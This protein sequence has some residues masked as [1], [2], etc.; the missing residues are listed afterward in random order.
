MSGKTVDDRVVQ[1]RFDNSQFE[2]NV[3]TSMSTLERLKNALKFKNASKGLD[4][5]KNAAKGVNMDA[6]GNSV[7]KVKH[8]FSALE[9]VGVTALANITNSAVNAGKNMIK[10]LTLDPIITGFQEYET[11]IN[12]VQTIMSNTA[13]KGTTMADVTR[14]LD[15]LN[16]YADLTIYNFAEMTRNIGTFTAAG[17]G[18]EDSASAIKGIANLAA[19]SGSNSYQASTAMYQ[20]SQ[21]LAAGTVK[22]MDWNSVVNAGM[23]GEKFQNALKAT[24]REMGIAVDSIIEKNGSFRD[25][26][27]AGWLTADVLNTT[28]KKFTREGAAEYAQAMMDAGKWT[29][30]QADALMKEAIMMEDAATK[31]KTFTQLWDTMKESVQSGWAQSWELIVGDFEEA[32]ASLTELSDVFGTFIQSGADARNAMLETAMSSNWKKLSKEITSLG[33]DLEEFKG[34]LIDVGVQHGV[35]T[36]E[37]IDEAGSFEQSLKSGW[38]TTDIFAEA[39]QG[40]KDTAIEFGA[41]TDS[42]QAKLDEFQGKVAA[43]WGDQTLGTVEDRIMALEAAGYDFAGAERLVEE[44]LNG[45][46][47]ALEDLSVAEMEAIGFTQEEAILLSDLGAKALESGTSINE[48]VSGLDQM[49]GRELVFDTLKNS[50][51]AIMKPIQAVRDAWNETFGV[52]AGDRLLSAIKSINKFS[53]AIVMSDET[54][55]KLRRT[56]KGVFSV[57]DIGATIVGKALKGGMTALTGFIK[58]LNLF[59]GGILTVTAAIGDQI[60]AFHD[61]A[62]SGDNLN[63]VMDKIRST[64]QKVGGKIKEFAIEFYELPIVQEVLAKFRNTANKAFDVVSQHIS[65]CGTNVKDFIESIGGIDNIHLDNIPDI[66][67]NFRD[68]VLKPAFKVDDIGTAFIN[69]FKTLASNLKQVFTNI[70]N[71]VDTVREKLIAFVNFF[72]E[73]ANLDLNAGSIF[74]AIASIGSVIALVKLIDVVDKLLSPLEG[75]T[76][77][78]D[79]FGD[80]LGGFNKKL[81]AEALKAN[82]DAIRSLAT[83]L[84]II[85]IINPDRMAESIVILAGLATMLVVLAKAF[86]MMDK[87]GG[88]TKASLGMIGLATAV[89]ILS[90]SM[91]Q[92][93][94]L[95]IQEIGKGF[96]AI[97]GLMALITGL[98]AVMGKFKMTQLKGFSTF[99]GIAVAIGVMAKSLRSL[100]DL[101]VPSLAKGVLSIMGLLA[102]MALVGK[103]MAGVGAGAGVAI[104]AMALTL[105][106][107][108]SVFDQISEIEPDEIKENIKKM[109]PIVKG[110]TALMLAT[111]LAGEHAAKAGVFVLMLSAGLLLIVQAIKTLSEIDEGSIKTATKSI[112]GIMAVM[113]LIVAASNFAGKY[114]IRAGAMLILMSG[115]ILIL[116]GVMLL[117]SKLDPS[118]LGRATA[119][120]MGLMA[121]FSLLMYTSKYTTKSYATL[122]VISACVAVLAGVLA[123]LTMIEIPNLVAATAAMGTIMGM[124]ALIQ[125]TAPLAEKAMGSLIVMTLC[126]GLLAGMLALLSALDIEIGLKNAAS[127]SLLLVAMAAS[128]RLMGDVE[129]ESYKAVGALALMTMIVGLLAAILGTMAALDV[130]PSIE[131]ATA[132]GLLMVA[133]GECLSTIS[134]ID[135]VS[136]KAI[137]AL[138]L[139]GLIVGEIGIIVGLLQKF[140]MAPT[141]ETVKSLAIMLGTFT[142]VYAV[143]GLTGE[144]APTAIEGVVGLIGVIGFI[145]TFMAAVGSLIT[146]FPEIEEFVNKGIPLLNRIAKGI[147]EFVGNIVGGVLSGVTSSLGD[148]GTHL[149]EFMENAMPFFEMAKSL[150][151]ETFDGVK[152]MSESV[153]QL[154]KSGV[155]DSL[156]EFFG[157]ESALESLGPKLTAF[158]ESLVGLSGTATG[159]NLDGINTLADAGTRLG[160]MQD[161]I[162]K[163]GGLKSVMEGYHNWDKFGEDMSKLSD[164]LL[165]VGEKASGINVEGVTILAEAGKKLGELQSSLPAMGGVI[166]FFKG[167]QDLGSF[168]SKLEPLCNGIKAVSDAGAGINA[169]NVQKITDAV[170]VLAEVQAILPDNEFSVNE[171]WIDEFGAMIKKLG[172]KFKEFVTTFDGVDLAQIPKVVTAVQDFARVA[173]SLNGISMQGWKDLVTSFDDMGDI[174]S[175]GQ[176]LNTFAG[177][178]VGV[179][180]QLAN[181]DTANLQK[182]VTIQTTL[183]FLNTVDTAG[184]ATKFGDWGSITAM[185]IGL[186]GFAMSISNMSDIMATVQP[187][188]LTK[189]SGIA[190]PLNTIAGINITALTTKFSDWGSITAF[191]MG[192]RGFVTALSNA[193]LAAADLNPLTIGMIIQSVR[194]FIPLVDLMP[195]MSKF[196]TMFGDTMS[197]GELGRQAADFGMAL[198]QMCNTLSGVD[199]TI[200]PQVTNTMQQIVNMLSMLPQDGLFKKNTSLSD[201]GS[202]LSDFGYQFSQFAAAVQGSGDI[203]SLQTI[204]SQMQSLSGIAQQLSNVNLDGMRNF[205]DNLRNMST[206]DLTAFATS[207]SNAAAQIAPAVQSI[208]QTFSTQIQAGGSQVRAAMQSVINSMVQT[209]SS[210]NGQMSAAATAAIGSFTSALQNGA[211]GAQ[212]AVRSVIS[213]AINEVTSRTNEMNQAGQNLSKALKDGIENGAKGIDTAFNTILDTAANNV[214]AKYQSFSQ[215]GQH[216]VDGLAAGIRAKAAAAAQA[217]AQVAAQVAAAAMNALEIRSPSRVFME[218]GKYTVQGLANGLRDHANISNKAA[219]N[220]ANG[221]IDS[222]KTTL[223]INSPSIVAR[224]EV[225]KYIMEGIAEGITEDMSAEEAASQKAQNIIQAFQDEMGKF[226]IHDTTLDLEYQ[227]W[228]NLN[229]NASDAEKKVK[230]YELYQKQ[231]QLQAERVTIAQ[232]QYETILAEF[233]AN[234]EETINAYHTMLQ[235]QIDMAKITKSMNDLLVEANESEYDAAKAY[236]EYLDQVAPKMLELGYSMNQIQ[237]VAQQRTG[238][239]GQMK[240]TTDGL[241]ATVK[242][243]ANAAMQNVSGTYA[244]FT[245]S[246]F[247]QAL[248]T[249]GENGRQLAN[250][251]A[252]GLHQATP[253]AAKAGEEMVVKTTEPAVQAKETFYEAGLNSG[254]AFADG[255]KSQVPVAQAAANQIAGVAQQVQNS[256]K[257]ISK[258]AISSYGKNSIY[259]SFD[260]YSKTLNK[261]VGTGKGLHYIKGTSV[262]IESLGSL[263]Y[264]NGVIAEG[265]DGKTY[266]KKPG[267]EKVYS[268]TSKEMAQSILNTISS[269][270]KLAVDPTYKGETVTNNYNFTQNNTSPKAI[271]ASETFRLGNG[272]LF[273]KLKTAT[274]SK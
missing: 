117:L 115:A 42:M 144:L 168:A 271:S 156:S 79:R 97:G 242:N 247:G 65:E 255:L 96:L 219:A 249:F 56:M 188:N 7:E 76:R 178:M 199:L 51:L 172:D 265:S 266:Y 269:G 119:C 40:Y 89:L 28:L 251:T 189:F 84:L 68:N 110:L 131:T 114:A 257:V 64:L 63:I 100:S 6:L 95:N 15:D 29:Q 132:L 192:L 70:G 36:Q 134:E 146:M 185:S 157:G 43:V 261:G 103:G 207:I 93:S 205:V 239:Y 226:D 209:A 137:G 19:A 135:D 161:A 91:M 186:K 182:M 163:I 75:L 90:K 243:L 59:E 94:L 197:L 85:S 126:V 127:L 224:D 198:S 268:T 125:K 50:I 191:G 22:L 80:V 112:T 259:N 123:A 254:A 174:D 18:L 223:K 187:E 133:M 32:K 69:G 170:R 25:S 258:A 215:A 30:E 256:A 2:S 196:S 206:I 221:V 173:V 14:T 151:P 274:S 138:A 231:L 10:A 62:L 164:A 162:P 49:S 211:R 27:Q 66:L 140:D 107:L 124:F 141:L 4:S 108:L 180:E 41:T 203:S 104:I 246:A 113:A 230:Q 98:M 152:N 130:E 238:Y 214:R 273:N 35:V 86:S 166:Q 181:V 17:V 136:F 227:L 154:T 105:K 73:N 260:A 175:F 72:K 101:D 210:S 250:Q 24:A 12:A 225:G 99:V 5:I 48:L 129:T 241:A 148:V 60:T 38:L 118:G 87:A 155:L 171:T 8:H 121:M 33:I 201:F 20:L 267:D 232:G 263:N 248:T 177:A 244:E 160:E 21:A 57:A 55:D 193:S 102:A 229:P 53:R 213:S 184:L 16:R 240:Q 167:E 153:L 159:I 149:T 54:A 252:Q 235:A 165:T 39:M 122:I 47:I 216:L 272:L 52:K 45:H 74:A 13:S 234:S 208:M 220:M 200:V 26:L 150:G 58:G 92:L 1:L 3:R 77:L 82:A 253:Q 116:S 236:H 128:F 46:T 139:M 270:G 179:S 61:W 212:D 262:T 228:E 78:L 183:N 158:A 9:V 176:N 120:V 202:Q 169:E 222:F 44:A 194:A 37:M 264:A 23:G 204:V 245:K 195:E 67:R 83:A 233:G 145:G 190:A 31:V 88:M 147:G 106:I 111:R 34:K 143:L 11:K 71:I 237:E 109:I 218:I 81:K 142:A 217:A